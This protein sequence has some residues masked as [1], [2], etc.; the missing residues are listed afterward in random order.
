M[1]LLITIDE[2]KSGKEN[3]TEV[4]KLMAIEAYRSG[5]FSLGYCAEM[6]GIFYADFLKYLGDNK[7]SIFD[8]EDVIND[9]E[10]IRREL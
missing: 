4:R 8:I 6:S 10:M 3:V 1:E 7:I 5:K 9:L 2:N